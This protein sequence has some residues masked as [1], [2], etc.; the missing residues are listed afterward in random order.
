M[1]NTWRLQL[2]VQFETLGTMHRVGEV[3]YIS[4]ATVSQQLS[5]LEKETNT[6]LFEKVGRR[7]QLTHA[8]RTLAKQVRPVLNQLEQIEIALNDT[9][10]IIQGTVRIAS[11]SS[12]LRSIVIPVV[13]QLVKQFPRLQIRLTELEPDK[14]LPALDS[15]QFDLAVVAYFEKPQILKQ[16][17]R[18]LVELGSDRLMVLVGEENPLVQQSAVCITKLSEES[19]VMEPDATYLSEYTQN[20]CSNA[21]FQ[22]HVLNVFQSYSAIQTAVANNLA[23]GILPKLAVTE[24]AEGV[25]LLDL[26]PES[27]RHIYL[28]A[29]KPQASNRSIQVV[30]EAIKAQASLVFAD[31]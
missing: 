20:L 24:Q 10:D 31:G 13:S 12:A 8:G 9:S 25:H 16:N 21:G 26:Q 23:I 19:W 5:I 1:L 17:D 22:P 4:T 29:R 30:M 27:T 2:L 7:V 28:V 6:I 3:M 15:H 14:S 18:S 11:F